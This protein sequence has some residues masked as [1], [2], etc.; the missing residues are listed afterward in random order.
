MAPLVSRTMHCAHACRT[1][2]RPPP[3]EASIVPRATTTAMPR[4][5]VATTA[6]VI[7]CPACP[8][9]LLDPMDQRVHRRNDGDGDE[10]DHRA[11]RDDER[12]LHHRDHLL[13]PVIDLLRVVV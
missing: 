2:W 13:E 8:R 5:A 11:H 3:I 9:R 7:D 10:A 12:R 1:A 6:S 4:I